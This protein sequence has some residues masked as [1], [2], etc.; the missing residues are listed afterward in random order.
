[1]GI[2][3]AFVEKDWFV[4]QTISLLTQ[5]PYP[6]VDLIF[7]GGTALSKAHKLI[8]RFSEDIDFRMVVTGKADRSASNV[9]QTLSGFRQHLVS[10]LTETFSVL[11]VESRDGNR[12]IKIDLAYPTFF[13][14]SASLRPHIKL[15]YT[16]ADLQMP[17]LLLPV[18]SFV[19]DA[20][21]T[22]PE[23]AQ[24]ACIDPV[25][26]AADK[27]SALT[28]RIPARI[29]GDHD[30]Q[31]DL[32]RHLHDLAKLSSRAL[33][34]PDF[35]RIARL[36]IERDASRET[37]SQPLPTTERL[38]RLLT[39]LETDAA[40]PAEYNTFVHGMSYAPDALVPTYAEALSTIRNLTRR[41]L[42]ESD[43]H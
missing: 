35:V 38:D 13:G 36:T 40:Y 8:E 9:R 32:V 29:R 21:R 15:E 1:M 37:G 42:I 18:S 28:W 39:I 33:S 26:N 19:S 31:P 20:A 43:F 30:R 22:P 10:V 2:G 34:S 6:A 7:T 4:T 11:S 14:I 5:H 27:L 24:I 41:L 3:E 23:V 12:Y 25:E 17:S 16:V